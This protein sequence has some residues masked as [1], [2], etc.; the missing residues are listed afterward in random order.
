MVHSNYYLV[1]LPGSNFSYMLSLIKIT[2]LFNRVQILILEMINIDTL[3]LIWCRLT[4]CNLFQQFDQV[5]KIL[6]YKIVSYIHSRVHSN[7]EDRN[8][9]VA[10]QTLIN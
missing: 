2:C 10:F 5:L 4:L 8:I 1:P 7:R 6:S 3:K 9:I